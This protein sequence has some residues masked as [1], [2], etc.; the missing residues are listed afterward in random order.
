MPVGKPVPVGTFGNVAT[1]ETVLTVW[2]TIPQPPPERVTGIPEP[3]S[4]PAAETFTVTVVVGGFGSTSALFVVVPVA[5]DV[6]P[7]TVWLNLG[8]TSIE[9]PEPE[10]T[11]LKTALPTAS[12]VPVSVMSLGPLLSV[13][14]AHG[15]LAPSCF[16]LTAEVAHRAADEVE[17]ER[18]RR[19]AR[20]P[21]RRHRRGARVGTQAARRVALIV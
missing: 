13:T 21:G 16:T 4:W 8:P 5:T 15:A 20:I 11:L 18:L 12:V 2:E 1:P 6:E 9:Y 7:E 19:V 14:G 3:T 10:G 17:R